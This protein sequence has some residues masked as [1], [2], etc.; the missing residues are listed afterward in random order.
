MDWN[1]IS[2]NLLQFR[3]NERSVFAIIL[4]I[5]YI[6]MS[7]EPRA[8]INETE[9][10]QKYRSSYPAAFADLSVHAMVMSAAFYLMWLFKT[11]WISVVTV[12]LAGLVLH[13]N[14]VVFH[15][16]CHDSYTP[17]KPLNYVLS[18][19]YGATTFT[20]PNW[21]SDHRVHHLTNG[22]KDNAYNFKF[23]ELLYY[24]KHQYIAF[25]PFQK[26]VFR[27]FH[28]PAVF[29]SVFP[30]LY[31]IGIQRFIY[32]LKKR[33]YGEKI[34]ATTVVVWFNHIIN[35]AGCYILCAYAC[36]TGILMHYLSSSYI[37]FLIN[38][39]LFFNQHTFNP[40]YV[41][42]NKEWSQR[43]CGLLG[44]SFIQMPKLLSYFTMGIEYH[45]IH[46][47]NAKIP[48]YNLQRYHE[49]VM[50]S[51]SNIFDDTVRL[52]M[53]DCYNNLWLCMYDDDQ[54]KYITIVEAENEFQ[55]IK[56]S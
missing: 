7:E 51:E 13:R 14:Y 4:S 19:I 42:S 48:G 40:A 11:S 15:D 49:E 29:F 50:E 27:V 23:N 18:T 21:M 36:K 2:F 20:S 46:H 10:F 41:V 56:Q 26:M 54:Q 1:K 35:N 16:C 55:K 22:N 28:T 5:S 53:T 52:T 38:F 30:L 32:I 33:K 37:G 9:L 43:K 24:N 3:I 44:S 45:H 34:P 8:R 17:S 12:P 31:F 47:I 6:G 39:L 25:T